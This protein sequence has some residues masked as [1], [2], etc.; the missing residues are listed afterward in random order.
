MIDWHQIHLSV[1]QREKQTLAITIIQQR[2]LKWLPFWEEDELPACIDPVWSTAQSEPGLDWWRSCSWQ[3]WDDREHSPDWPDG[4]LPAG[5][6]GA[7]SSACTCQPTIQSKIN[8]FIILSWK[9]QKNDFH[10]AGCDKNLN[11]NAFCGLLRSQKKFLF[12]LYL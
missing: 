4:P 6:R 3:S 2:N 1:V 12:L 11:Q 10:V 5:W 9:V 8:F 7:R